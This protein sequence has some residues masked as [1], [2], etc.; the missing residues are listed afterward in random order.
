M[1]PQSWRKAMYLIKDMRA[2]AGRDTDSAMV[3]DT[4]DTLEEAEEAARLQGE[5]SIWR[6]E[7]DGNVL[8]NGTWVKDIMAG[9][10]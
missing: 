6:Y 5:G 4:A 8:I 3:L 2:A 7:E 10:K 9:G 1:H